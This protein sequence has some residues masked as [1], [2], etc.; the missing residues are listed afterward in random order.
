[1]GD[2]GLGEIILV[3][4]V[5][6]LLYGKDLPGAARKAGAAYSRFRSSMRDLQDKVMREVP[7]E[8]EREMKEA[9]AASGKDLFIPPN[10]PH[11]HPAPDSSAGN[12][13][14]PSAGNTA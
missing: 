4:I 7:E 2:I 12:T 8:L 13:P 11:E 9:D 3:V 1:M 10:E 5:A 6:L 14:P